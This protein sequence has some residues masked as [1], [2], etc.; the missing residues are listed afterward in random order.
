MSR[1]QKKLSIPTVIAVGAVAVIALI[2]SGA[3]RPSPV[4]G[5]NPSA[6]PVASPSAPAAPSTPEPAKPDPTPV[7]T[8]VPTPEPVDDF[9]DGVKQVKLDIATPN[10]VV[11]E[12]TDRTGTIVDAATGRAGDG[13]SVRWNELEVVNL[14]EDTLRL[15]WV[16]YATDDP[17]KV[18]VGD[19]DNEPAIL[20]MQLQPPE[21]SDALGFDRVLDLHF[22]SAVSADD[23]AILVQE[24]WDTAG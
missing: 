18:Q 7:P 24:G 20:L 6:P 1:Y 15:T 19:I 8:P 9:S 12:I 16:G 13:M 4:T 21:N 10:D 2:A 5:G 22:S 17:V 23:F 14:D 3:L 11:V